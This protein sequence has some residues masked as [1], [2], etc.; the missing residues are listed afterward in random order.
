MPEAE[1]PR[2]GSTIELAPGVT[3][4]ADAVRMTASRSSGPGG[5]NVNKLNTRIEMWV[6]LEAISGLSEPA[7]QKLIRL[8][9]RRLTQAGEI[10]LSSG[11]S[12]S[13]EGNRHAVFER[14][15]ELIVEAQ[16]LPRKRR[17]TR[18]TLA[19]KQRRLKQKKQRGQIKARRRSTD[20]V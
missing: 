15:R 9:G 7:R 2:S 3:V 10:H 20:D 19:S 16:R 1:Q 8:L 5:Q 13:Q 17:P 18:P 12:R 6:P 4:A 14:L 11:Q